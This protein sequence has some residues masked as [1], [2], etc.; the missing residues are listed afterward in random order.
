MKRFFDLFIVVA[1]A[2]VWLPFVVALALIVRLTNGRPIFFRQ[3]RP[4]YRGEIFTLLKFRTMA[5]ARDSSG[6][7]LPD[8][9]RLGRVGHWLRRTSLDELPELINILKGEMSLVGPRPLLVQYLG[10]YSPEQARRHE[11][12]PGLTGWAQINGR[13]AISWDEKFKLDTWYVENRSLCLDLK[14]LA[15]TLRQVLLRHG[16]SAPGE[17]TMPEFLG[18]TFGEGGRVEELKVRGSGLEVERP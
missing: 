15:M 7:L 18:N 2:P 16:I 14:I 3:Q 4:G 10:R 6:K 17:A 12:P 8:A 5:D 1:S 13:N 9:E 11:V